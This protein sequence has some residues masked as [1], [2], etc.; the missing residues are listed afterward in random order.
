MCPV[1]AL[2]DRRGWVPRPAGKLVYAILTR[3]A[4]ADASHLRR[5]DAGRHDADYSPQYVKLARLLRDRIKGGECKHGDPLPAAA[6]AQEHKVPA[7]A[8]RAALGTLAANGY[9][10]RPAATR[11]YQVTRD[12]GHSTAPAVLH[13][14][15]RSAAIIGH[16]RR[17]AKLRGQ[18]DADH[19]PKV[20]TPPR[21][22]IHISDLR[23]F[24]SKVR[25]SRKFA[26][27][28]RAGSSLSRTRTL[29]A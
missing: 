20:R 14:M 9:A 12:A 27:H 19:V 29:W 18:G 25:W 10:A 13:L 24:I 8:A 16:R 15:T 21:T 1:D 4:Q 17:L 6:L 28:E 22:Q 26:G 3:Q 23:L 5:A 7:P 11:H 2:S